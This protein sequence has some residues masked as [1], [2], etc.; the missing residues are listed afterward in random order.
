[1]HAEKRYN[2]YWTIA[3]ERL[4]PP[5]RDKPYF[6]VYFKTKAKI[7]KYKTSDKREVNCLM[8]TNGLNEPV[9]RLRMF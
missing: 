3:R 5:T 6:T 2:I 1:M 9:I 4:A 7:K 8:L